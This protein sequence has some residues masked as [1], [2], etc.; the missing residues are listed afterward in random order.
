MSV[1]KA[2]RS[3]GADNTKIAFAALRV[4]LG[5]LFLTVWASNLHRG[6]YGPS[7]YEALIRRYVADGDAP[8]LWKDVMRL[9]ADHAALFA[10]VQLIT[11]LALGLLLLFGA[12]IRPT[13]LVAWAFLTSLWI[14]ELGVP[15]EWA[16]SLVFPAV[17]AFVVALLPES[18]Y[19][20]LDAR[21]RRQ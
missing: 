1:S 8:G 15:G 6:L 20:S 2:L 5:L 7:G 19:L 9:V 12:L 17:I 4:L 13:G 18:R 11:E 21:W 14:S 10:R 16:W 3:R